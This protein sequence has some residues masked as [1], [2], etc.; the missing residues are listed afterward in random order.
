LAR[1]PVFGGI[2][3]QAPDGFHM[4][5]AER[6][7][8]QLL[9]DIMLACWTS[10]VAANSTAYRETADMIE[11]QLE[12]GGAVIVLQGSTV[13]G[14]GRFVPVPG[15]SGEGRSWV[16]LKR[17]GILGAYH[18]LGLGAPLVMALEAEAQRRGYA[19]AQIGVRHDQPRLV[20]FWSGLGYRVASDVQLHTVNPL[21]PPPTTMRKEF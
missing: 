16:E 13:V 8:A 17:I 12:Q 19:G 18:K 5:V 1:I 3:V 14:A 6:G 21:T 11:G 10:T 20:E 2:D 9:L 15:P 7:E 4:R